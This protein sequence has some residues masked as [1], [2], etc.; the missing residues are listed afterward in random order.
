MVNSFILSSKYGSALQAVLLRLLK[1]CVKALLP[2]FR[3][4]GL[5][6]FQCYCSWQLSS[7]SIGLVLHQVH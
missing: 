5:V 2:N 3:T 6:L 7:V 4:L 1:I